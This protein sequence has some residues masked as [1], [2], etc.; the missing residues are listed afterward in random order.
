MYELEVED[1]ATQK[2]VVKILDEDADQQDEFLGCCQ[3]FLKDLEPGVLI[4]KWIKLIKILDKED[5]KYRGEVR[6]PTL[7]SFQTGEVTP[8]Q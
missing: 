2:V 7:F 5:L 1:P 3:V 4:E 6:L 8:I